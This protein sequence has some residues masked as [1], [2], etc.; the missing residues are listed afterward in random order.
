MTTKKVK[1]QSV[2]EFEKR[3]RS[4][5]WRQDSGKERPKYDKWKARVEELQRDDAAGYTRSQAVVQA[6]KDWPCLHR[7]F[8]E[9]D[10]AAHDPNPDS[11][12]TRSS[13]SSTKEEINVVC[14]NIEQSYRDSLRWAIDAAGANLISGKDPETCPCNAAWWLYQQAISEPKDFMAKVS[15]IEG[16][17]SGESDD[18]K[19]AKKSGKRSVAELDAMLSELEA[20]DEEHK[21]SL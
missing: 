5:L 20:S 10:L 14:E 1:N 4:T 15:Q 17:G 19:N 11:H 21:D 8:R 18:E 3:V 6:S 13:G 9:Y 12:P 2:I 7:L 16:R